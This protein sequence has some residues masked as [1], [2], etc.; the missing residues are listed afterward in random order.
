MGKA[1]KRKHRMQR[2]PL[3]QEII[4]E[5]GV[6]GRL[7]M[8]QG[9][10]CFTVTSISDFYLFLY[11]LIKSGMLLYCMILRSEPKATSNKSINIKIKCVIDVSV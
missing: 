8:S 10:P 4:R 7:K 3:L 2:P 11:S 5:R 9:R 6:A 1:P